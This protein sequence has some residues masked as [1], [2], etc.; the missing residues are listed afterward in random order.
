MPARIPTLA[1][2]RW[3][4]VME[5][6]ATSDSSSP[7]V[8]PLSWPSY[9]C[10]DCKILFIDSH[11]SFPQHWTTLVPHIR[12]P[13]KHPFTPFHSHFPNQIL[14]R[15]IA[16]SRTRSWHTSRRGRNDELKQ[17]NTDALVGPMSLQQEF[18]RRGI[19]TD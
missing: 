1:R 19:T 7:C 16:P 3:L 9:R 11:T 14:R 12:L 6:D 13:D 8:F 5:D 10:T 2:G 4:H 15:L 18:G 17:L